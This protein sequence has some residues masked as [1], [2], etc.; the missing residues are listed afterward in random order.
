MSTSAPDIDNVLSGDYFEVYRVTD[1]GLTSET[2]TPVG[3]LYD[4]LELS[5]DSTDV[6]FNPASSRFTL[7]KRTNTQLEF[8]FTQL[9]VAGLDDW[10]DMGL[11]NADG[12]FQF[13]TNEWEAARVYIYDAPP[14]EL[15][16]TTAARDTLLLP[17]F[18]PQWDTLSADEGTEGSIEFMAIVNGRPVL[19][20]FT[21]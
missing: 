7:T 10:D 14:E 16:D 4:G 20:S 8:S 15:T 13:G 11:I 21:A 3:Y 5:Q 18:G 2:E 17:N 12:E 1:L 9:Y 19:E 6:D